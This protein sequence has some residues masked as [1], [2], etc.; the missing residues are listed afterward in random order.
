VDAIRI[1]SGCHYWI[2]FASRI[3]E[4]M[5]E[6][7]VKHLNEKEREIWK[8]V[9]GHEGH[10][11][12]SN[13]GRVR[14]L[15]LRGNCKPYSEPKILKQFSW[16]NGYMRVQMARQET[17][18]HRL[19]LETFVGPCPKG[20]E[21]AHLN[22]VRSDNRLDNLKWVTRKENHSHKKAHGTH[23]SGEKNGCA[24]MT[25]DQARDIKSRCLIKGETR[26][27]LAREFGLALTTVSDLC[28]GRRWKH[29]IIE[30][31]AIAKQRGEHE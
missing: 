25:D 6:V 31:D 16:E 15:K 7:Y 12:V 26:T 14:S 1:H 28:S 30:A 21:A 20:C 17:S 23:Q 13:L 27:S 24:K 8:D 4:A 10:H 19:V 9:S 11:Q 29:I 22:G 5:D 3:C 18:V 2:L